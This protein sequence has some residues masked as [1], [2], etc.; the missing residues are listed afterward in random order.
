MQ[1]DGHTVGNVAYSIII[2]GTNSE[3]LI[4]ILNGPEQ[5]VADVVQT[6]ENIVIN[7]SEF[8]IL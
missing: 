3:V 7:R 4:D 5:S 6:L 1:L 2:F 8:F